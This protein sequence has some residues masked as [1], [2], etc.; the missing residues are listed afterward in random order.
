MSNINISRKQQITQK[1]VIVD[2]FPGC[3]KTMLAPIISTFDHVEIMQY[4]PIIEQMCELYSLNKVDEDVAESMI[5]MNTDLLLYNIMMGRNSNCRVSDLSSIFKHN[6]EEHIKRMLGLGDEHIPAIIKE[7]KPILHLTTHMLF[8]SLDLLFKAF[9]DRLLFIEV[10]RHPLYTIIQQEKNFSMFDGP[11]NPHIRY[12]ENIEKEY[13]FFSYG[14]EN[15]YDNAN[16]F[17]KA[18]HSI[19]WYYSHLFSLNYNN[20]GLIVVPFEI[21][22]KNPDDYMRR[23]SKNLGDPVNEAVCI[24]M[25][26]QKIPRENLKDSPPLE[27]YKRC[28]W[29]PSSSNSEAKELEKIRKKISSKVSKEAL[30]LLDELSTKYVE[31][32]L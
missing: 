3:G 25:A 18:I 15:E 31:K 24:E 1:I 27:I 28:G 5:K 21:F 4:A 9:K 17:E 12:S 23:F 6:P 19:N 14:K 16:S 8:P 2:G 32:Y 13:N 20:D 11:R 29:E 30:L 10:V 7:K 22:V 26:N